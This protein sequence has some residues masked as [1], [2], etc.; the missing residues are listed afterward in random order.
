MSQIPSRRRLF[1]L[2]AAI[3][4]GITA[5]GGSVALSPERERLAPVVPYDPMTRW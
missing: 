5:V 3:L 2:A 1:V 4:A